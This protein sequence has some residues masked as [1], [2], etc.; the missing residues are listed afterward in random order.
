MNTSQAARAP[1]A[2]ANIVLVGAH[3]T[4]DALPM[5][6][7]FAAILVDEELI[8]RIESLA[9]LCQAH[10]L[11]EARVSAC[12]QA[13]GPGEIEEE[14]RLQD[15]ELVVV[16][17]GSFWFSDQPKHGDCHIETDILDVPRLVE[18]INCH[19]DP[20]LPV[21]HIDDAEDAEEAQAD[22]LQEIHDLEGALAMTRRLIASG[23][24]FPD[25]VHRVARSFFVDQAELER[26]YDEAPE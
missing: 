9:R 25:V 17:N 14:L 18:A 15:G 26:V 10:G 24:E 6:P 11:T 3:A 12:P 23:G 7:T 4:S 1:I 13:W 19:Q 20:E 8:Q 22:Y 16:R 2:E 5:S 21:V